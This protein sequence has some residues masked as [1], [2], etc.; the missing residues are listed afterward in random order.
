MRISTAQMHAQGLAGMLQRQGEI[1]RTQNELVTGNRLSS[2]SVDP[3]AAASAQRLD[4]ALASLDHLERNAGMVEHRL[5]AQE[6]GLSDAGDVLARARELA[7]QANNA[8]LSPADRA[9]INAEVKSLATQMLSIANRDD[10]NGRHLFAGTRDGVTPFS[11]AGG[12][13]TY[14]GDDGRNQVEIAPGLAVADTDAGSDV[15]LRVRTGDGVMRASASSANT[16]GAVLQAADQI[17]PSRWN[18]ASLSLVFDAP[19]TYRVLA[20]DGSEVAAGSYQ[21]GDSVDVGGVQLRLTGSP[22]AGDRFDVGRAP[23]QDVFAT[24]QRLSDALALPSGTEAERA[25]RDNLM[26]Q[27][28]ADLAQ[29]QDHLLGVRAETGARLSGIA[30][31]LD[32]RE[33]GAVSLKRSLSELRDVDFAEAASRLTLQLTALEAAQSTMLRVQGMSLFDRLR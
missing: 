29:A 31:A 9:S 28:I 26:G 19:D 15:F 32:T 22:E 20:A 13:T 7:I 14:A 24:L 11:T 8:A 12:I 6:Q 5:W 33:A 27:S 10:G 16:G 17:D 25:R 18:G 2:A 30:A 3:A 4:H 21:P 1:A 23:H